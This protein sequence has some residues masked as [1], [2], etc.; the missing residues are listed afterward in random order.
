M[1]SSVLSGITFTKFIGVVVLA[2]SHSEIF[3]IYYFRMYLSI[4][5]SGALHGLL[6]LPSLLVLVGPEQDPVSKVKGE[7]EED[8]EEENVDINIGGRSKFVN[9]HVVDDEEETLSQSSPINYSK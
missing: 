4:V 6:F 7:E 9:P 2:F 5:V 8:E 1:G 3:R